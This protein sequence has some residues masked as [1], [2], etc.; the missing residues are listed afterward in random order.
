MYIATN[1][2][3]LAA[4]NR[5][6]VSDDRFLSRAPRTDYSTVGYRCI[7]VI[8]YIGPIKS[9]LQCIER[10]CLA[11]IVRGTGSL[12]CTVNVRLIMLVQPSVES[13]LLLIARPGLAPGHLN[14]Q[15]KACQ[16]RGNLLQLGLFVWAVLKFPA[17][18]VFSLALPDTCTAPGRAGLRVC[19]IITKENIQII[20]AWFG[21]FTCGSYLAII[22]TRKSSSRRD[23]SIFV[24]HKHDNVS[25]AWCLTSCRWT[26]C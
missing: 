3:K 16:S 20:F 14:W 26:T 21:I 2:N 13:H 1:L 24:V 17:V 8:S 15:N 10:L 25:V 12:T 22:N 19:T 4:G 9:V 6:N 18:S 7:C 5:R 11:L 23:S